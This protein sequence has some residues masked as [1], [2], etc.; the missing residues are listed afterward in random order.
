MNMSL[1]EGRV[2]AYR[3]S[4][5]ACRDGTTVRVPWYVG[6]ISDVD[7]GAVTLASGEQVDADSRNLRPNPPTWLM[8]AFVESPYESFLYVERK[9]G[10]GTP[11]KDAEAVDPSFVSENTQSVVSD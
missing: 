5:G 2:V 3:D 8:E 7:G 1:Y 6:A 4:E 10:S 11:P 9:V